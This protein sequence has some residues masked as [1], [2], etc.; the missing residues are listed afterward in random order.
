MG[1]R[2]QNPERR[3]QTNIQPLIKLLR[4]RWLLKINRPETGYSSHG[5]PSSLCV[6]VFFS[7]LFF[8][9]SVQ[10]FL[11]ILCKKLN[12]LFFLLVI[13][14]TMPRSHKRCTVERGGLRRH[15]LHVKNNIVCRPC[16]PYFL[17]L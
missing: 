4:L 1:M 3:S 14:F 7:S 10:S 8:I 5:L 11:D 2:I 17:P 15:F 12:Y 9:S 16:R 13:I 6:R